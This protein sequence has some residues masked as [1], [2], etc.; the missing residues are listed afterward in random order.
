MYKDKN[1]NMKYAAQ[2][3]AALTLDEDIVEL[4]LQFAKALSLAA[5]AILT[6]FVY[7]KFWI[8]RSATK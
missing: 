4:N 8:L 5:A 2:D 1:R 6:L 3:F 7:I